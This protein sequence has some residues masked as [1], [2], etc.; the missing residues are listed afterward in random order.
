[1]QRDRLLNMNAEKVLHLVSVVFHRYISERITTCIKT[2]IVVIFVPLAR[3]SCLTNIGCSCRFINP[4][5][6]SIELPNG[7]IAL[8]VLI[9]LGV[10]LVGSDCK[11]LASISDSY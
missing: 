4:R 2:G 9:F 8:H 10:Y 5:A 7:N 11:T 1:M 3:S 6:S